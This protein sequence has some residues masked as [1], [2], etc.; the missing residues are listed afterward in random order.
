M[1]AGPA[2]GLSDGARA[3]QLLSRVLLVFDGLLFFGGIMN[4]F[5]IAGLAAFILL[6][7]TI[8]MGHWLARLAG[9]AAAT[10]GV[11]M[12]AGAASS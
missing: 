12:L 5:W 10:W 9:I 6:E 8:P 2:R 7:K 4:L 1:A 3:R 11:V